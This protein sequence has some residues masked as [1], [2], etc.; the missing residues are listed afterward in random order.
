MNDIG[1]CVRSI[2]QV[3][4][5]LF[6]RLVFLQEHLR[7]LRNL[8]KIGLWVMLKRRRPICLLLYVCDDNYQRKFLLLHQI[9]SILGHEWKKIAFISNVLSSLQNEIKCH[10]WSYLVLMEWVQLLPL[11]ELWKYFAYLCP[12]ICAFSMKWNSFRVKEFQSI[13]C[14]WWL[15]RAC[16]FPCGPHD[17]RGWDWME[18]GKVD[19]KATWSL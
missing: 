3:I 10:Q 8:T 6:I 9:C 17:L 5:L 11:L 1:A 16:K 4:I 14:F 15:F 19:V 2:Y 13:L 18:K 7:L 12:G